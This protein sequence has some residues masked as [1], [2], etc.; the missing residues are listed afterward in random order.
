MDSDNYTN[1]INQPNTIILDVVNGEYLN[2][3]VGSR[4]QPLFMPRKAAVDFINAHL[5]YPEQYELIE[6]SEADYLW[7]YSFNGQ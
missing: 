5:T 7:R 4:L 1:L 3:S 2:I 6:M